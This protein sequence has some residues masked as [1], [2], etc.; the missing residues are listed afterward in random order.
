MS[1]LRIWRRSVVL[2]FSV[3]RRAILIV[4][5]HAIHYVHVY[6]DTIYSA[7]GKGVG[8]GKVVGSYLKE[9]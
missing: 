2:V 8:G 6:S 1:C 7:F 5:M 4:V 3:G 9:Q